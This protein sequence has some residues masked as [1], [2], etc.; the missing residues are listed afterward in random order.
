M[1]Y[2]AKTIEQLGYSSAEE[3]LEE[4]LKEYQNASFYIDEKGNLLFVYDLDTNF[5]M[6]NDGWIREYS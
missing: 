6:S 5:S 2:T 1:L 4:L 3:L